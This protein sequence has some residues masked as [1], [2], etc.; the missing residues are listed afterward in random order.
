MMTKECDI[1]C[2]FKPIIVLVN[3]TGKKLMVS[4][5]FRNAA[6]PPAGRPSFGELLIVANVKQVIVL[7]SVKLS[8][9]F[10][11]NSVNEAS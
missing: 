5:V 7:S 9:S 3:I 11:L 6:K 4:F 2:S 8:S 10:A 1:V